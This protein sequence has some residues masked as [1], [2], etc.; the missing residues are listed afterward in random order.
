MTYIR[1]HTAGEMGSNLSLIPYVKV[2]FII[3]HSDNQRSFV[4]LSE[5]EL[6]ILIM[7]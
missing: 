4:F 2:F 7:F 5:G 6:I 1:L 3:R